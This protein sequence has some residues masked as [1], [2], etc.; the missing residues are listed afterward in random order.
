MKKLEKILL[1]FSRYVRSEGCSC[2]RDREG[3]E[4]AA[5]ELGELLDAPKYADGSGY[6]FYSPTN[7]ACATGE[8]EE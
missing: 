6:D 7:Q 2:C 1:A 3:H 4:A 5:N 8:S